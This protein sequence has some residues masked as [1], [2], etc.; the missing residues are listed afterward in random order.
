MDSTATRIQVALNAAIPA[1][2][3]CIQRRVYKCVSGNAK[4]A[5]HM[6][7]R[8]VIIDLLIGLGIPILQIAAG[9]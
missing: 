4:R 8:E 6:D 3:L 5:T 9:N 1:C 7:K 2:S